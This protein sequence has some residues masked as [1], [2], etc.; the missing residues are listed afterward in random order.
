VLWVSFG[1]SVLAEWAL[2]GH[3]PSGVILADD[4]T[5]RKGNGESYDPQFQQLLHEGVEFH[6]LDT[7]GG[8]YQIELPDGKTGWIKTS[9]AEIV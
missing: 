9:Q 3:R 7:R 4:V 5:V 1:A 6:V 8:W 2:Q